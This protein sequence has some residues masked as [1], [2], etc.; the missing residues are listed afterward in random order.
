MAS[1]DGSMADPQAATQNEI[2]TSVL[3]FLER[4][5][6]LLPTN[7]LLVAAG[8]NAVSSLGL[9]AVERLVGSG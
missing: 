9:G 7:R 8:S 6:I 5:A 2:Y 1:T 4:F 3:M